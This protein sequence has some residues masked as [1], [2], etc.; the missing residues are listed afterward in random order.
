MSCAG[1]SSVMQIDR[2]DAGVDG[3]VDRV[4]GEPR[5]DEDQ[6]R[7]RAG[8]LDRLGDGVEDRDALDVLAALAGRDAGDDV[9]PVVAVAQPVEASPRGRSGPGRRAACRCRR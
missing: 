5:R 1:M 3:L 8:L 4:G 9:R 7:V 2:A 6:R